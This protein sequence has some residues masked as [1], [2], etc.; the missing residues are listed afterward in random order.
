MRNEWIVAFFKEFSRHSPG[1]NDETH[2]ELQSGYTRV[3]L[4]LVK[5]TLLIPR[6]MKRAE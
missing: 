5:V 4:D 1:N 6:P 3:I 2:E